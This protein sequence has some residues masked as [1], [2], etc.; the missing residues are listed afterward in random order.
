MVS[1]IRTEDVPPDQ[2]HE[3]WR[4]TVCDT[5]GPLDMRID[6]DAPL[7]GEI[8]A[9]QLGAVR[10]GKVRTETPHSVHRTPGL[11]R[12]D[13]PE[14]YR[15]VL[16]MAGTHR[17]A[18]DGRV[19]LVH[20]GELAIYDFCRPY[21]LDYR[22][23]VQLAVF[24]FRRALLPFPVEGV[25]AL[26]AVPMAADHGTG[27][28]LPS[29]LRRVAL[30]LDTFPPASAARLSTVLLDVITT[31]IAERTGQYAAQAPESQRRT[32]L[33]RI[34]AFIEQHLADP[35]LSPP[36]I[37]AAHHISCRYL[38]RLFALDN[39]TVAGW[40]RQRR[41]E[42]CRTDLTDPLLRALPVS[43][44][45]ARRG[46]PDPAHFS[47]LFRGAYGLPPADYRRSL[48]TESR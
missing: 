22:S 18:Q 27:A 38:H 14:N 7:T 30:D 28:I 31:T 36:E 41:L 34:H 5:L 12:R 25:A 44:I 1:L 2:R 45:A 23:A 46:L 17:L 10:V 43:A 9:G 13:S 20:T 32:L 24:T 3:A 15:V 4:R 26:T 11:I 29:L 39:T 37:A 47:R 21:D 8:E 19:A 33:L 35:D 16:A 48:A 42:R 40:V 6:P